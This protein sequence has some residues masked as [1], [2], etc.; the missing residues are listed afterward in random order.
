[1]QHGLSLALIFRQGHDRHRPAHL[2]G[3]VAG[4]RLVPA[5]LQ[6][7]DAGSQAVIQ[8]VPIHHGASFR[9]KAPDIGFV[10]LPRFAGKENS[11]HEKLKSGAASAA[12][13]QGPRPLLRSYRQQF[14]S[15]Q[16][17]GGAMVL[18][19]KNSSTGNCTWRKMA[20]GSSSPPPA[21]HSL[22]GMQ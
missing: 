20:Q 14:L 1:M 12:P 18:G 13:L 6:G 21:E 2:E 7:G 22:L 19:G 11:V 4:H 8:G 10:I 5:Q 15:W 9:R 17:S 3:S 16:L